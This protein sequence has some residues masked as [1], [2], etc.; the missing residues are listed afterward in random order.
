M[1]A[2]FFQSLRSL[3]N[4]HEI[5][6][7]VGR[8]TREEGRRP[9]GFELT[10]VCWLRFTPGEPVPPSRSVSLSRSSTCSALL[11]PSFPFVSLSYVDVLSRVPLFLKCTPF[12][13]STSLFDAYLP[14][15]RSCLTSLP[16]RSLFF[17][18]NCSPV[19][20]RVSPSISRYSNC[21]SR[22]VRFLL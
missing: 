12:F 7:K 8:R 1:T 6:H 15:A 20:P 13:S 11:P 17:P 5:E 21:P 19:Q 9:S 4:F 10:W 22:F 2:L 14:V 16:L 3:C 18:S